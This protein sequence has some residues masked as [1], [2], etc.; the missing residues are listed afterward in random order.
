MAK[1]LEELSTQAGVSPDLVRAE[2]A[3]FPGLNVEPAIGNVLANQRNVPV[4]APAPLA[5]P[6]GQVGAPTAQ[7][8]SDFSDIG[9][10]L[11][12]IREQ[13]RD[14]F[15]ELQGQ[16][17][18]EGFG[19][20]ML[21][22][23]IAALE[24]ESNRR[25]QQRRD[26]INRQ[27]QQRQSEIE[28]AGEFAESGVKARGAI[29]GGSGETGLGFDSAVV[30][31][32][33]QVRKETQK[34]I[35][36]LNTRRQ[37]ALL[38]ADD[39]AAAQLDNQIA[40]MQDRQDQLVQREID[41]KL[42]LFD[43]ALGIE[44]ETRQRQQQSFQNQLQLE[45]LGFDVAKFNAGEE[46]ASRTANLQELKFAQDIS[47][48]ER[49][50]VLDNI[51]ALANA[52]IGP[53]QL[54]DEELTLMEVAGGFPSGSLEAIFEKAQR[55][56]QFGEVMDAVKLQQAQ[57]QLSRTQQLTAGGTGGGG[58]GQV[59]STAE[60]GTPILS[61]DF[62]R[63]QKQ[64][65]EQAQL[66]EA[67]REE[68]LDFLFADDAVPLEERFEDARNIVRANVEERFFGTKGKLA[69][70]VSEEELINVI[71]QIT[72]LPV[73]DVKRLITEVLEEK[74]PDSGLF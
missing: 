63:T 11:T 59:I 30:A 47:E 46:R 20:S 31:G 53:E 2:I 25:L 40:Q 42:K 68:Q 62:T 69:G 72:E 21:E 8:V 66:L 50:N 1:T 9:S 19:S 55:D 74:V 45:R 73:S 51:A 48:Q 41:L 57:A 23:E 32:V 13:P 15:G 52:G 44:R 34:V 18:D 14:L 70:G 4:T 56:A 43:R 28:E 64:K 38:N 22:D 58:G 17:L 54:T 49:Q 39:Q 3:K 7:P 67:P 5:E 60:D 35:N 61:S 71:R 26:V 65:L 24:A 6:P 27:F 16:I 10:T 12:Q 29:V 33:A 36:D 37:D